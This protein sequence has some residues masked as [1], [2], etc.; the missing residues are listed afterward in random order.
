MQ[1]FLWA[2]RIVQEED[3]A[4]TEDSWRFAIDFESG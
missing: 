4:E 1:S 3:E 2:A